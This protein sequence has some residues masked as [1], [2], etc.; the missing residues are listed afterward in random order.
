VAV[1][2]HPLRRVF[3]RL[4]EDAHLAAKGDQ[5]WDESSY[6]KMRMTEIIKTLTD[7]LPEFLVSHSSLYGLLC[8]GLHE[9]S[10]DEC[11]KHFRVVRVGIEMILDQE[12]EVRARRKKIE[13]ASK[14]INNVVGL[15]NSTGLGNA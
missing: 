13:E 11:L 12:I 14:A 10:E 2:R 8:K 6:Q 4:V 5:A 15:V 3:E 1:T 9:L 7:H